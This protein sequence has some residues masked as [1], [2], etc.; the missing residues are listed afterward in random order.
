MVIWSPAS[1]LDLEIILNYLQKKWNSRIIAKF[2]NKIDD[3]IGLLQED[4]E[5]F[6]I[7]NYD[8]KIRK[9]VITKQNTLYYRI[10]IQNIEIVRL[11]DTRQDSTKLSF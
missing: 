11:F 6:P 7:I 2:I 5:I 4:P 1:E 8:L 10:N 9:C 3:T